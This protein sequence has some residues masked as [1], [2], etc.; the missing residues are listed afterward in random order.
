M[1][2]PLERTSS[3]L[4]DAAVLSTGTR[5]ALFA[6]AGLLLIGLGVLISFAVVL[7]RRPADE[8]AS[9]DPAPATR[10]SPIMV[11][12]RGSGSHAAAGGIG[13]AALAEVVSS[14]EIELGDLA[15]PE[16][17]GVIG[18]ICPRCRE[19]YDLAVKHC[20][21]DGAELATIN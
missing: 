13:A 3:L 19:R 15:A 8:E 18:R 7:R 6:L 10:R 2:L 16:P 20:K 21:A 11:R 1:D 14:A 12:T 4:V 17:T 9:A 5:A